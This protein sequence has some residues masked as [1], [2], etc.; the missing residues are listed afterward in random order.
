MKLLLTDLFRIF[1][2]RDIVR[3]L[4][5]GRAMKKYLVRLSDDEREQL[6]KLIRKGRC[7]ARV[8]T[9]AH[10]LLKADQSEG[11]PGWSDEA[12]SDAYDVTIQTVERIRKQ[13]VEEGFEA[14]L[15]RHEYQLTVPRRKLDGDQEAHLTAL[16]CSQAPGGRRRWTL[17]LLADS[18]VELG[19]VDDISHETVRQVLKKTKLGRG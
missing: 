8:Y 3:Y 13:L 18:L 11:S 4:T 2:Q 16:A 5:F 1:S 9:R 19:V 12:I 17:R 14:T 6:Q 10:V 7:P 15:S